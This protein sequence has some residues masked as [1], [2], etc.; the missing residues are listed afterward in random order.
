LIQVGHLL[1]TR[2]RAADMLARLGGDEFAIILR[3]VNPAELMQAADTFRQVLEAK[4]FTYASK[5]Y[6]VTSSIGVARIDRYTVSPGEALSNA[7]L[8]CH[9]AKQQGRNQIHLYEP[10]RDDRKAMDLDLG[11]SSRLH[12]ALEKDHFE[13][14]FHPIISINDIPPMAAQMDA[15]T[16]WRRIHERCEQGP[17]HYEVL[18]RLDGSDGEIIMPDAFLPTAERFN[19]MPQIDR[20]VLRRSM[21]LL[22]QANKTGERIRLSINLSA[23]TIADRGLAA[24]IKTLI[25]EY[26]VEP[27][28]LVF[29]ITETSAITNIDAARWL[30]DELRAL[31]CQFALDDFGSG[32]CSFGHLKNLAVD[33]IKI[34][35]L[36]TQGIV[37]DPID[38][39][40]I[41]SIVDIAHALGKRTIAEFVETREILEQLGKCGVDLIQGHYISKPL[42]SFNRIEN[43]AARIDGC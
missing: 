23:H 33:F 11:W 34:D 38:R 8:A 2:L 7:D 21:R 42:S 36:F 41:L 39:A 26:G 24:E 32:F 10:A 19:L 20:W 14:V 18:L 3:N 43:G 30:I 1:Q 15:E 16:R 12:E 17:M 29:E 37:T 40:V 28:S 31:G 35:G 25:S 4:P 5:R 13:L 9:I 27:G 6:K 22:A